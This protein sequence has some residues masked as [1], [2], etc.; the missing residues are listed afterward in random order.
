MLFQGQEFGS[1]KPFLFFADHK[2]ELN[3]L[4]RAGRVEFLK[5]WRSLRLPEMLPCFADPAAEA[6]FERCKLDFAEVETHSEVYVLHKDLLR[7]RREDPVISRQGADGLDGATLSDMCFVLRYFSPDH[8]EDRLLVVNLGMDLELNPAPEP[9]L[10]PPEWKDW[11]KL[12][13]SE[14]PDYGGCGTPPV[15]TEENWRIPGESAVVLRPQRRAEPS[16][17]AA[18]KKSPK[19]RE[20]K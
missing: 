17:A 12:W 10:A 1:S 13:S 5:Q 8:S 18:G 4:I 11:V 7:L 2:P 19:K 9:L 14:D 20:G 3:E 6:T 15:D 16:P